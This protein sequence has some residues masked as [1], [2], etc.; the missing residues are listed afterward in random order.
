MIKELLKE[1]V[2]LKELRIFTDG[3]SKGNPG[4]SGIGVVIIEPS[5]KKHKISQNIGFAT[6]NEAEYIAVIYALEKSIEL[7]GEII[8]IYS[9]SSLIVNQCNGFWKMKNDRLS[10][11][12]NRIRELRKNFKKVEFNW[13]R[14][15]K[16]TEADKLSVTNAKQDYVIIDKNMFDFDYV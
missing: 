5:G 16:N 15:E 7:K 8:K 14:R 1:K 11:Y 9:D 13:I 12:L 4:K 10:F 2:L 3:S 6:C